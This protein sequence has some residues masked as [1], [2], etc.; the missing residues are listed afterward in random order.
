MRTVTHID[1]TDHTFNP[2]I[3]CSKIS[4]ACEPCY[5]EARD[6][7]FHKG[8]HWGP[9]AQRQR[10]VNWKQPLKWD[11]EA[12]LTGVHDKVFCASLAD[13]G[14]NHWSIKQAWRDDLAAL[15]LDT[16]NLD[17]Q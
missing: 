11:R 17:W 16:P 13:I 9:N 8:V 12:E 10:T 14:D 7:R 4:V 6:V 5:A 3:G 1:W 15:V 2:W